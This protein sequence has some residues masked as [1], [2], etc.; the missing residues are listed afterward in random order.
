MKEVTSAPRRAPVVVVVLAH[1]AS[2]SLSASLAHAAMEGLAAAGAE[3]R[4]H[5]LYRDGFDP[6]MPA[7]EVGTLHLADALVGRYAADV[8]T[9]DA[10]VIVHPVWFFSVPAVL[11][12]WIDRVMREGIVYGHTADG[13]I[14]G[15]IEARHALLVNTANSGGE[16][17][18]GFG[19]DSLEVLWRRVI[20]GSCGVTDVRRLRFSGVAGSTE[21][22][23]LAWLSQAREAARALVEDVVAARH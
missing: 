11:K 22:Q 16:L 2:E 12:G 10:F 7:S 18:A 15:L 3:T 14:E 19:G 20:L 8:V 9:A 4:F 5:D 17:E 13:H 6:R 23:R 21:A 1:P